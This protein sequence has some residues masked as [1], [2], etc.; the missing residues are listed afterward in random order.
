MSL[1]EYGRL[2]TIDCTTKAIADCRSTLGQLTW[3]SEVLYLGSPE[4]DRSTSAQALKLIIIV[5]PRDFEQRATGDLSGRHRVRVLPSGL[6]DPGRESPLRVSIHLSKSVS[7]SRVQCARSSHERIDSREI[8]IKRRECLRL[9]SDSP[10]SLRHV[11]TKN[12]YNQALRLAR[13]LNA[14]CVNRLVCSMDRP[15]WIAKTIASHRAVGINRKVKSPLYAFPPRACYLNSSR[16]WRFEQ[17]QHYAIPVN[18]HSDLLPY[19][20]EAP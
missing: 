20:G 14:G 5:F 11:C 3:S 10:S 15:S 9:L 1:Y 6:D 17:T 19:A 4:R 18:D 8:G 7:G 12:M 16:R 13:S 2:R